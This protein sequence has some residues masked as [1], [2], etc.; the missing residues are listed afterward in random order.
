MNIDTDWM[1]DPITRSGNV[2]DFLLYFGQMTVPIGL[3]DLL[4]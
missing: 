2:L 4:H 3:V 1:L